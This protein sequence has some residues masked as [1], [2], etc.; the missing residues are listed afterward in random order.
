M[1]FLIKGTSLFHHSF[2][3]AELKHCH[4]V[5]ANSAAGQSFVIILFC[6]EAIV[7]VNL[8]KI[9]FCLP[10]FF[11]SELLLDAKNLFSAF[12]SSLAPDVSTHLIDHYFVCVTN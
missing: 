10:D 3:A 6:N 7:E 1:C 11:F 8:E 2:L 5:I 9:V 12:L 4:L